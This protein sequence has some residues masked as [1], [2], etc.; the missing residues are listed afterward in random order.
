MEKDP[1]HKQLEEAYE[2]PLSETE[3]RDPLKVERM[4]RIWT[5]GENAIRAISS[6][7]TERLNASTGDALSR[8][9]DAV[10]EMAQEARTNAGISANEWDRFKNSK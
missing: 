5:I 2:H 1:F 7:A 3:N 4:E 6:V 8:L 10:R 9:H